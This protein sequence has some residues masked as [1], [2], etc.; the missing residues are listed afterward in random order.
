MRPSTRTFLAAAASAVLGASIA[1]AQGLEEVLGKQA[2]LTTFRGLVKDHADIFSR[3]PKSG[4]TILAPSDSAYL[5]WQGW[6]A[7]KDAIPFALQYG[8]LKGRL[9]FN[10]L[11]RGDS[12]IESTLLT[13]A[14]FSNVTDG[15]QVLVTKQPNGDVVVTSGVASRT[16]ALAADIP[17]DG[18]LIQVVDSLMVTPARLETTARD[19]YLEFTSF[20]GALYTADLVAEFAETKDVTIF[21][22]RNAAFQQVAGALSGMGRDALR[23]VLRYHLVPSVVAQASSLANA[24][25][26]GTAVDGKSVALTLSNNDIFVDSARVIQTNILVANG[27]IQMIDAVLNVDA[28]NVVP[29]VS[30]VSQ[31]P[32]FTI[33]GT[34]QTGTTAPTPF[35]SALPCTTDCPGSGG[36]SG[37]GGAGKTAIGGVAQSSSTGGAAAARCTGGLVGAAAGVGLS[38][39]MGV[40]GMD[41]LGVIV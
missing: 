26:L 41:V 29:D 14:R 28:R 7:D 2:N 31:E 39:A 11:V 32:V 37:G 23:R 12:T 5:K 19:A 20:L 10:A 9:S 38:L 8:V 22:P 18:G 21:A 40:A 13:D 36:G 16:T 33:T 1:A 35:V 34:P 15:Q 25:E 30:A 17:F 6:D 3:L 27:V 24:T 4:V